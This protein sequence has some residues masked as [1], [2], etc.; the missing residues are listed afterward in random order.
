MEEGAFD[1]DNHRELG[2]TAVVHHGAPDI[3]VANN[4]GPT[5]H[6]KRFALTGNEEYQA[7]AGILQHVVESVDAAIAATIRNGKRRVIKK[8]YESRTI[9]LG[10]EIT[11]PSGLV[12]PTTTKGD[13]AIKPRHRRSSLCS[14]LLVNHLFAGPTNFLS[15]DSV[16]TTSQNRLST[17]AVSVASMSRSLSI[18]AGQISRAGPDVGRDCDVA[19]AVRP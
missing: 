15:S 11:M 12:D 14:I 13:A 17:G 1:E 10:R 19:A 7:D 8:S 6:A 5:G 9:S 2:H 4:N 18:L 16:V 3:V